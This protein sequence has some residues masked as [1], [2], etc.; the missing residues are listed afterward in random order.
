MI[1]ASVVYDVMVVTV[2]NGGGGSSL[3]HV[4]TNLTSVEMA[5]LP[6]CMGWTMDQFWTHLTTET[7]AKM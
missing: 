3:I 1:C 4:T 5:F 7:P 6:H 2:C